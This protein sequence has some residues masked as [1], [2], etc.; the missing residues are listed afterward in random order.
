[1]ITDGSYLHT[2]CGG[3]RDTLAGL[4]WPSV[5]LGNAR[6]AGS[7]LA[8]W[9]C[10]TQVF[11]CKII[12]FWLIMWASEKIWPGVGGKSGP[13]WEPQGKEGAG[14]LEMSGLIS[15]PSLPLYTSLY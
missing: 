6:W 14:V 8:Q 2:P 1:M 4:D 11:L 15:G 12:N 3:R 7:F 10:L 13:V 5:I 9:A